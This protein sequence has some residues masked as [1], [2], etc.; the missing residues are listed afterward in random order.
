MTIKESTGRIQ[1]RS[2]NRSLIGLPLLPE[3]VECNMNIL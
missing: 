3:E 2:W 1:L